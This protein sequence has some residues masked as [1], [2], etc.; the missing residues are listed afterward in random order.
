MNSLTQRIFTCASIGAI[1]TLLALA[2]GA[3]YFLVALAFASG[4]VCAWIFADFKGFALAVTDRLR[5]MKAELSKRKTPRERRLERISRVYRISGIVFFM[6]W[7]S[8]SILWAVATCFVFSDMTFSTGEELKGVMTALLIT[9]ALYAG[10]GAFW[11]MNNGSHHRRHGLLGYKSDIADARAFREELGLLMSHGWVAFYILGAIRFLV[12]IVEGAL[13]IMLTVIKSIPAIIRW[14]W[15]HFVALM[16]SAHTEW[17]LVSS[18]C[19][20][21]GMVIGYA[22]GL[23]TDSLLM[24]TLSG[25]VGGALFVI[26]DWF[27]LSV[28]LGW[29]EKAPSN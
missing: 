3:N 28:A 16:K 5:V 10:A 7:G 8:Q 27:V 22:I 6:V 29:R 9:F 15:R 26:I 24:G 25:G 14:L 18:T 12:K 17:R 11:A 23:K 19:V 4:T 21:F 13:N 1:F 20:A 2:S